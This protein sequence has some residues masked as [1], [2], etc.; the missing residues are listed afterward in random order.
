M[1]RTSLSSALI[2]C[3][4]AATAL[5]D[6]GKGNVGGKTVSPQTLH[7][8]DVSLEMGIR[9]QEARPLPDAFIIAQSAAGADAHSADWLLELSLGVAYGVSD[10]L[11]IAASLPFN[12]ISNFRA[13]EDGVSILSAG[14][15]SGIGDLT[16]L[17]KFSLLSSP[18]DVAIVAGVKIPT[19]NTNRMDDSGAPLT[20]DHQPGTGTWD[21]IVGLA[22]GLS[23]DER[24]ILS[25]S[26]T[27]HITIQGQARFEPG[28]SALLATKLQV[29]ISSLGS[30]PRIYVTLELALERTAKDSDAG[31]LNSDSGGWVLSI[32][33]GIRA[34]FGDHLSV[35]VT[36]SRP[37]YQGLYGIQHH[38]ILE[39][40][41][42]VTIDF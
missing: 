8:G 7:E 22:A 33:P 40:L 36:L 15:I 21:P 29:Q 3:L 42:G 20:S 16:V 24:I 13:S 30:F 27:W 10:R 31:I 6:H 41:A 12:Y 35:G 1:L 11:T 23:L 2:L 14:H 25:A 32:G 28:D 38:E 4:A 9:F 19:G 39:L 5:A 34:R 37:L 17:G 18:L 26:L